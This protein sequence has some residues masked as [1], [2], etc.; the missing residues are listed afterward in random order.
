LP[1]A[2]LTLACADSWFADPGG[3][4]DTPGERVHPLQA[5]LADGAVVAPEQLDDACL[6]GDDRG[7]AGQREGAG[8]EDQDAHH[9]QR[10]GGAV[11]LVAGHHGKHHP[12]QQQHDARRQ[13]AQAGHEPGR[14]LGHLPVQQVLACGGC[15]LGSHLAPPPHDRLD[16]V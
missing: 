10:H 5:R 8:D 7:Q 1:S 12:G 4:R 11:T 2:S 15:S 9:D 3:D 6:P 16:I 14:A 13:H